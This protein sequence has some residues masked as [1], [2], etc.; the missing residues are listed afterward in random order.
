VTSFDVDAI[1]LDVLRRRTS[2]KWR[3]YEPDVI[4]AWVAEMDYPLAEPIA[5]ALRRALAD[6]DT[7]YAWPA[8]LS[9]AFAAYAGEQWGWNV[10]PDRVTTLPDVLTGVAQ[11]LLRLTSPGDGVVITPPVYHPFF[12]VVTDVVG[13]RVVEAPLARS[14]DDAYVIDLDALE[15]AF[16]SPGV[17]AFL[18][19]NPHNPT[20]GVASRDELRAVAD[21]AARHGV[22]VISDEIHA[23]LVLP[24]AVHVPF[25]TVVDD[26]ADAVALV[27]ASKAW[28]LA[29]LKASQLVGTGRTARTVTARIPMEVTF[30]TGHLGVIAAAAAYREGGPWLAD[31]VG[32]LD[33]QRRLLA[34]LLAAELPRARYRAP[35]ASYLGWIDLSAYGLGDDPAAVILE[36]GRV[37]L[38]PGA[39]FGIQGRGFV[40][41][42]FATS[43]AILREIVSRIARVVQ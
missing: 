39:T 34:D 19:S 20:G 12:S 33:A 3:F 29:G 32:L 27:S 43:P 26:D 31:V 9:E 6:S 17:T 40:R 37:G 28:N 18:M 42:N 13:R 24:G 2:A 16:A 35:E 22:A 4:P 23:P 36:R 14:A 8:G 10:A 25:L 38:S 21:L 15:R 7:G 41:L 30:T 5:E 1:T 11:A